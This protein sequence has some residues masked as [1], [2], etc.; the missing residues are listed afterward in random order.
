[1]PNWDYKRV[2]DPLKMELQ[3]IESCL[4]WVLGNDVIY[5][6]WSQMLLAT[7][8]PL[9]PHLELWTVPC[10]SFFFFG[11]GLHNSTE[12]KVGLMWLDDLVARLGATLYPLLASLQGQAAF[13]IASYV[14]LFLNISYITHLCSFFKLRDL[15]FSLKISLP[16]TLII[17]P[18][19]NYVPHLPTHPTACLF[20]LCL[21]Q[22]KRKWNKQPQ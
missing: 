5:A 12:L 17:F 4:L 20:S 9:Q 11:S 22:Q 3:A 14:L 19:S 13:F 18:F 7:K 16:Y 6:G 15:C 8:P 21:S 1:M 2:S 10:L